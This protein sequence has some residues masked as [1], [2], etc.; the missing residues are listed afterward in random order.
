MSAE[1][2]AAFEGPLLEKHKAARRQLGPNVSRHIKLSGQ[3][4]VICEVFC[5]L[6]SVGIVVR[7]F[8]DSI[9][10]LHHL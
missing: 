7:S 2:C 10:I 4:E 1:R 8:N 6:K 3:Q 9:V 5:E